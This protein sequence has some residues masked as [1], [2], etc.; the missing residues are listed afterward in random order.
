MVSPCPPSTTA[1]TFS[2]ETFN[3]AAMN[4]RKRA[5]SS[6]PA[7]PITRFFG[8][9]E[10]WCA[11]QHIAS[12]GLVTS[13]RIA[14]GECFTT[15]SVTDLTTS[16]IRQQQIVA[17]HA[18]FARQPR[19][20]H[21]HVR[22]RGRLII[23]GSGDAHVI[24]F[25]RA[26]L[27]AYP[28]LFRSARLPHIHQDHVGQFFKGEVQGAARAHVSAA[29]YSHFIAHIRPHRAGRG[30]CKWMDPS[31]APAPRLRCAG[32]PSKVRL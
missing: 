26:G 22:I 16:I 23:I 4:V 3:S 24:A 31:R 19:R 17:A 25:D 29:H 9:F 15:C 20:D 2:T 6:T 28:A 32:E 13:T 8:N 7:I 21:H 5:V 1:V 30:R 11:V 18:R 12:S 10:I 27:R 14:F